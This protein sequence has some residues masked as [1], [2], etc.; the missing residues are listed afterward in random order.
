LDATRRKKDGVLN[1]HPQ[2]T[3]ARTKGNPV[4][5]GEALA[6]GKSY[7]PSVLFEKR[8]TLDSKIWEFG[9]DCAASIEKSVHVQWWR[10]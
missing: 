7:M 9:N 4:V 5:I 8:I 6:S 2:T 1:L 10:E 3:N